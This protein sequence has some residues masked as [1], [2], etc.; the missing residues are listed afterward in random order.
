MLLVVSMGSSA[1]EIVLNYCIN[2]VSDLQELG[3]H[4]LNWF[5]EDIEF[6]GNTFTIYEL[7]L[8]SSLTLVLGYAI[9]K[10]FADILN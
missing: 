4:L 1:F 10:F 7:F 9:I 8:G 5:T 3:L 6:L 2:I